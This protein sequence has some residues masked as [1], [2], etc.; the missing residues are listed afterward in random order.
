[1]S[2]YFDEKETRSPEVREAEIFARLPDQI[3]HAKE[4]APYF[5]ALFADIDAASVNS[6]EALAT[7]PL[8][9]KSDLME[10]Q[11]D[12]PV[13]P[14]FD[15][16]REGRHVAVADAEHQPGGAVVGRRSGHHRGHPARRIET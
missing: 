12:E 7:L 5:A 8:T 9:R 3:A 15:Q 2:N 13:L 4:N 11:G 16:F 14:E 6:R 1:M 10:K